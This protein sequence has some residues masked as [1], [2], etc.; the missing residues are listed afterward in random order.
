MVPSPTAPDTAARILLQA[1]RDAYGLTMVRSTSPQPL[2]SPLL[3]H[4][5]QIRFLHE[6]GR[7]SPRPIQSGP[8]DPSGPSGLTISA[9]GSP[10]G[11][12]FPNLPP[13][14]RRDL[15]KQDSLNTSLLP[16]PGPGR[17]TM[18]PP[19]KRDTQASSPAAAFETVS[20]K[21]DR[22]YDPS[23]AHSRK[24]EAAFLNHCI[25][26]LKGPGARAGLRWTLQARVAVIEFD[27]GKYNK[28]RGDLDSVVKAIHHHPGL[29]ASPELRRSRLAVLYHRSVVLV[30][31]GEH[32]LAWQDLILMQQDDEF[33]HVED[34]LSS[35]TNIV[36]ETV[37]DPLF[38]I[39]IHTNR[40]MALLNG[41]YGRFDAARL[42]LSKA[43]SLCH[44]FFEADARLKN[45]TAANE[46]P[47]LAES[48]KIPSL[49]L[50]PGALRA[51]LELARAKLQMIQGNERLAIGAIT[52]T[53]HSLETDIRFGKRHL[54][55]LEA[56]CLRALI[57]ARMS[58]DDAGPT[59][60]A[61]WEL[62]AKTMGDDHPLTMEALSTLT[63]V[64]VSRSRPY[65]A[66]DT[67]FDLW[68]R[69]KAKLGKDNPQTLR[70]W[71]QVGELNLSMGNYAKARHELRGLCSTAEGKWR[72][73]TSSSAK[74][75]RD[76]SSAAR[77]QDLGQYPDVLQYQVRLAMAD[78]CLDRLVEAER[79]AGRALLGQLRVFWPNGDSVWSDD[80]EADTATSLDQLVQN[81]LLKLD[82]NLDHR[83]HP[84]LLETLQVCATIL[85]KRTTELPELAQLRSRL[86]ATI[87]RHRDAVLG[88]AHPRT[89]ASQL[90]LAF[91]ELE[92]RGDGSIFR[93]AASSC[94]R[95]L[96]ANH[97]LTWRAKLGLLFESSEAYKNPEL[98]RA[99]AAANLSSQ[100]I[101]MG[102]CHPLV[103]D[104]RWRLFVYKLLV[105]RDEDAHET[106]LQLLSLLRMREVR[107]ERLMESLQLEEK[108]ARIYAL[109]QKEYEQSLAIAN[110]MLDYCLGPINAKLDGEYRSRMDGFCER[111]CD[112]LHVAAQGL[113]SESQAESWERFQA[114]SEELR[115]EAAVIQRCRRRFEGTRVLGSVIYQALVQHGSTESLGEQ[116]TAALA[117]L[118]HRWEVDEAENAEGTRDGKA[119]A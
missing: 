6:H 7:T 61:T 100:E 34:L 32:E 55:T 69:A 117:R 3:Q 94:A 62:T 59:C 44:N 98:F 29:S 87:Y 71:Y 51:K 41:Y 39:V 92:S 9:P 15:A 67:A 22:F 111:A 76:E 84:E 85:E 18:P 31:I 21:F 19:K 114:L 50:N 46:S 11:E 72:R 8:S 103:L 108:V 38:E 73:S 56:A 60:E 116:M 65:E 58:A 37:V 26:L 24:E 17:D 20:R 75:T 79:D 25:V 47:T 119:P 107:Q 81:I 101:L 80:D 88:E 63:S 106:G 12:Y 105:Y 96:G 104:S 13:N 70:Y 90:E 30:R 52:S 110:H 83:P 2:E 112:L 99:E 36:D 91:D 118:R 23:H 4:P 95:A 16:S 74:Q 42:Y 53:L 86:L 43:E 78:C 77:Q 27:N 113:L 14:C 40:L 64:F 1:Q 45:G 35:A 49:P 5:R 33:R 66:L 28:A 97:I 48:T 102:E 68:T 54:L 115:M 82:E 89:L 57:L 109:Q 93:S 10:S